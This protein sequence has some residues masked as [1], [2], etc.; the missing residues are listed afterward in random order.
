MT[1]A[2]HSSGALLFCDLT[3]SWSEFG[4]GVGTYLRRKRDHI[5]SHTPHRHLLI[6]PGAED[7]VKEKGR[8][9]TV[10]IASPPV[11]GSPN[12]RLLLRNGAVRK[13]LERFRPDLV[14]CQD[15][16]NLP[17]TALAYRK[18]HP[19]VA[20]TAVYMTDFPTAYIHRPLKPLIGDPVAKELRSLAYR[21][22]GFLYR[23]FDT[24][25]ALGEHG[26]AAKL[27]Q[28]GVRNIEIVPLGVEI[29]AF[30]PS[31][32]DAELRRSLGIHDSEPML[33]YVGRLD[34]ER[35]AEL[36][37]RAFRK[38][39]AELGARLVLVGEGPVRD[40]ILEKGDDRVIAPGYLSD[41]AELARWLASADMYVSAMA[42]ETFG[43]SVI[44][45]QASGLPVVGVAAGGM[46]D[47]VDRE[48]G[49]LG[50]VDDSKA[51]AANILDVWNSDRA[52]MAAAA[53]EHVEGRFSWD[54]TFQALF[55][56]VYPRAVAARAGLQAAA[57]GALARSTAA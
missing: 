14:D 12:Y 15:G 10:T 48:T 33:I 5:L 6:V 22:C 47:R 23:R 45:A 56:E 8:A 35:R 19:S 32:R 1:D 36:V 29:D 21:Y 41:R 34:R 7:A 9:I 42:D 53:R 4:G 49:R 13:A 39:P 55:G 18:R 44:E 37:V 26:G 27:R 20:V 51:M 57:S 54:R 40:S 17:W 16:Y 11:P 43:V 25:M 30:N 24:V 28:L 46:L 31:N 52:A 3:Q 50:P 38:L 2:S